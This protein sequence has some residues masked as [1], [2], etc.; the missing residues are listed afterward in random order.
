MHLIAVP[1][2]T[3]LMSALDN[4]QCEDECYDY[5]RNETRALDAME[6]SRSIVFLIMDITTNTTIAYFSM[7]YSAIY[8]KEDK[9]DGI[10]PVKH[11]AMEIAGM[12]VDRR[13]RGRNIGKQTLEY[14][15]ELIDNLKTSAP[16]EAI[17][18]VS[19]PSIVGFYAKSNFK[20]LL[21]NME[22]YI[23]KHNQN[24]VALYRQL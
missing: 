10:K 5:I 12:A 21:D 22:I 19:R 24:C 1:L 9:N 14:A 18:L 23:P 4:F 6:N 17:T 13:F 2:S 7:L 8:V 15:I 16:I 20:P 11:P 3:R